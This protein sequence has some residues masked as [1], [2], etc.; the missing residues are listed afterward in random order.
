MISGS[1]KSHFIIKSSELHKDNEIHLLR[2]GRLVIARVK[3][4]GYQDDQVVIEPSDSS[5]FHEGD[6]IICSPLKYTIQ[7]MKLNKATQ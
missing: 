6:Y 1:Q 7:G 5:P 4:M 2:D 3:I